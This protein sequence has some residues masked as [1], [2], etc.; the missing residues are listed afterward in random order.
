M[1]VSTLHSISPLASICTENFCRTDLGPAAAVV[2]MA[3]IMVAAGSN[4][5]TA[6]Q[7]PF[8]ATITTGELKC[9]RAY[10]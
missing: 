4:A 2:A 8:S 1:A 5:S 6:V 3:G 7:Y 9:R 10:V